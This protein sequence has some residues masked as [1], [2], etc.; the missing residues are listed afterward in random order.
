MMLK[1]LNSNFLDWEDTLRDETGCFEKWSFLKA[2]L[3]C[4]RSAE[5]SSCYG[6]KRLCNM[7][8]NYLGNERMHKIDHI[9]QVK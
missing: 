4:I 6:E 3:Y 8:K 9:Q 1:T 2:G 7:V 5:R